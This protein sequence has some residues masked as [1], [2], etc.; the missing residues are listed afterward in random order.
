MVIQLPQ[1]HRTSVGS[2]EWV[3][4]DLTSVLFSTESLTGTPTVSGSSDL[5]FTSSN[6][7]V[8]T[9]AYTDDEGTTV[10]VGKAVQFSVSG[11]TAAGSPYTITVTAATNNAPA[12]TLTYNCILSFE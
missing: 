12:R 9:A 7:V 10:A 2:E 5:T 8:N 1:H 11:G 4:V 6:I 3:C